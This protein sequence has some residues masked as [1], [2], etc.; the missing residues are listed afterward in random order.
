[1]NPMLEG[2]IS[3]VSN[4]LKLNTLK[5]ENENINMLGMKTGVKINLKLT[6]FIFGQL[7][8]SVVV[9]CWLNMKK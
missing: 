6:Y 4:F 8:L 5:K 2:F 1:M 9:T 3:F 7:N